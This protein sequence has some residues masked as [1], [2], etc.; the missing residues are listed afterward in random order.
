MRHIWNSG[1]SALAL[2]AT[3]AATMTAGAAC[4]EEASHAQPEET[5]QL[6]AADAVFDR[7]V[8]V[9]SQQKARETAGAA[10]YIS[11]VEL[12]KFEYQ[13][14]NRILR[15]VPGVNLQEE[16]G[17]GLRPNI[18]LR[19]TGLDRSSKVAILEDGVLA[20]PAPYA[21][22]SAYYFPIAGRM[23]A[24][25]VV[26]GPSAIKYGPLTTGGA[27]NL[28]STAIPDEPLAQMTARAGT[29]DYRMAHLMVGNTFSQGGPKFGALL[30][31]FHVES[32]GFKD[33]D[34]GGDTGFDID[35]FVAKFSIASRDGADHPQHLQIKLQ[36][37]D[38]L[39]DETYLGLTEEDYKR[40]AFRRYRGSQLDAM[41]AEHSTVQINHTI[42]IAPEWDLTTVV[43]RNQFQRNW[44]KLDKVLDGAS[45]VSISSVL[46]DPATN[47]E[48]FDTIVGAPGFVS[49][50]DA[51]SVKNNNREYLSEGI[52]M[53]LGHGATF[54]ATDHQFEFSVRY[55]EDEEDRYQWV[56]GYRMDEG[57]MV[58]T[59]EGVAGTDSN[60]VSSAEAWSYFIRDEIT[61]GDWTL[62]PGLRYEAI[63]LERKDY[64][65]L[66][67]SRTGANLTVKTNSVD[68]WIPGFGFT[69]SVDDKW[70]MLGGVYKGFTNP[71]PGSTSDAEESVNYE[72]GLRFGNDNITADVIAFFND[73]TNLV[74]TCTASIGGGCI[75][76]DQFDGGKVEVY[77]LEA[78]LG[79]DLAA[80]RG[81]G[82]EVPL[83]LAY[84]LTQ[85]EF[86]TSFVSG[87]GPW[88]TVSVGDEMPYI[89]EHQLNV[90]LGFE[91]DQW[92][93][94]VAANYVSKSRASAGRGAVVAGDTI[95]ARILVDWSIEYD[96]N[97]RAQIFASAEN[98]FD[99]TYIASR[100][101]AGLRPGKPQ[102]FFLG[103]RLRY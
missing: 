29:D 55:H 22:P 96:V 78:T 25:E 3:L 17:F 98:L 45:M 15:A 51:L 82:F 59:S 58:L 44:Y 95:D 91:F 31:S 101:P 57:A 93:T 12:E 54:G 61:I 63:D 39:S 38:E 81:L 72:L 34:S 69:Y 19:G 66:D 77:G 92:R 94:N 49:A 26:K 24:V 10:Q 40:D 20:A 87:Y 4:A 46:S 52:Q 1:A 80:G 73:Y 89:P 102:S 23:S 97:S 2:A 100:S 64:G 43:Y 83:T 8:V 27:V 42:E 85:T 11:E 47:A 35:D 88:G 41:D 56:D 79:L 32:K 37:S 74:G 9:G 7:I 18:G 21:A 6:A 28:Y 36:Y 84:T 62:V 67:P 53:V 90:G 99:E 70:M 86:Q 65:K 13:D 71:S 33:L 5:F 75:I 103:V 16:D 30:E 14:V 50:D 60:R 76:G 68:V 48:A